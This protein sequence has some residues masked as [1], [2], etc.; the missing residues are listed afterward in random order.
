MRST[1]GLIQHALPDRM[2]PREIDHAGVP[3]GMAPT[4]KVENCRKIG[5]IR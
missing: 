4:S 2:A 1:D 3:L 5:R